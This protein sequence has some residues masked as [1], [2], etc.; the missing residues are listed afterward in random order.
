M[1]APSR[2]SNSQAAIAVTCPRGTGS[3]T[4]RGGD[5]HA[6]RK[7]LADRQAAGMS[8]QERGQVLAG[9]RLGDDEHPPFVSVDIE[10]SG[11]PR[12]TE[13]GRALR[14]PAKLQ[15]VLWAGNAGRQYLDG[16]L[17]VEPLVTAVPYLARSAV[18]QQAVKAVPARQFGPGLHQI[19]HSPSRR[20]GRK[21]RPPT[22]S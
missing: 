7:R 2:R 16:N 18:P 6:D 20:I 19:G 8:A 22:A 12:I 15:L 21:P 10:N 1:I 4:Q 13:L 9:R 3:L 11:D 5:V 17:T 14:I